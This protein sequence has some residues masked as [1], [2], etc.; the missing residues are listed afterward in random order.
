MRSAQVL[1]E[2]AGNRE[3]GAHQPSERRAKVE[4][5]PR[6][7]GEAAVAVNQ[8]R[9]VQL[10]DRTLDGVEGSEVLRARVHGL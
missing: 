4:R 3:I 1:A 2:H 6:R 9:P 5:H 10:A 8:A 7:H